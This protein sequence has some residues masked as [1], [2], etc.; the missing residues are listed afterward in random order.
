MIGRRVAWVD[1]LRLVLSIIMIGDSSPR[2]FSLDLPMGL[3][4]EDLRGIVLE[5]AGRLGIIVAE[6]KR[7]V[8]TS[9]LATFRLP[10]DDAA[11]LTPEFEVR[12]FGGTEI[13]HVGGFE[14]ARYTS[15]KGNERS[16]FILVD[17]A[18]ALYELH[19]AQLRAASL[20]SVEPGS[21]LK[22]FPASKDQKKSLF[23]SI[24][25]GTELPIIATYEQTTNELRLWDLTSR[26]LLACLPCPYHLDSLHFLAGDSILVAKSRSM[27]HMQGTLTVTFP[28]FLFLAGRAPSSLTL[29]DFLL[30]EPLLDYAPD[31][32]YL[33]LIRRLITLSITPR[34]EEL[35]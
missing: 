2:D 17:S 23:P 20:A 13:W 21:L 24:A 22:P 3:S 27:N 29:E 16:S 28:G 7:T 1:S 34:M 33:D 12:W 18:G 10:G 11:G 6:A 14:L 9:L 35:V 26:K 30:L 25:I 4:A 8:S 15:P 5:P 19:L 32:A 31:N